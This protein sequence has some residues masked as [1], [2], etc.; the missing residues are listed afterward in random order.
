MKR[1]IGLIA[2]AVVLALVGTVAVY[3][4]AHNADTRAVAATRST[5]VLYAKKQVPAGTKWSDVLKGNYLTTEKVPVDSAPTSAVARLD[6]S[7]P[8]DQVA[9]AQIG[10]GQIVV[11]EMFGATTATTGI[12]AIPK[13]MMA[14][15]VLLP[16]NADVAGF[17][18]NGSQVAI[19]STF[20]VVKGPGSQVLAENPTSVGNSNAVYSTKQVLA[21]VN[22]IATSQDAPSEL[23]GSKATSNA[24]SNSA[25]NVLVTLA[26]SQTEAQRLILAQQVGQL[27]LA[28]LSDSSVSANDGGTANLATYTPTPIFVK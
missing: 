7:I 9:M 24:V 4:Y 17:V 15:S 10:S 16:A 25:N 13:G 20:A 28:L 5:T 23:N 3:S 1:R 18:Q 8:V 21:R 6:A 11:R 2:L 26:L 12:L 19:F 14:I 22:V 27:Y